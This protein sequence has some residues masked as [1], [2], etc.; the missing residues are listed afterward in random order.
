MD[1]PV[2]ES[3]GTHNR[4]LEQPLGPAA[5]DEQQA[6]QE[7]PGPGSVEEGFLRALDRS[8]FARLAAWA[9]AIL[10]VLGLLWIGGELHYQGCVEAAAQRSAGDDDLSNLVR[11][12]EVNDCSRLP[13]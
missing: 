11:M 8:R 13:F 7:T 4:P 3:H 9:L 6:R 12:R 2:A 10:L 1:L 5:D